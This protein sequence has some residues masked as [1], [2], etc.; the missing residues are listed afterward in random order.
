MNKDDWYAVAIVIMAAS[1]IAGLFIW[2]P[3]ETHYLTNEEIIAEINK[4]KGANLE[5][6][7]LRYDGYGGVGMVVCV[8][9]KKEKKW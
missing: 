6:D 7:L 2:N 8:P 1:V 5:A 9:E 3:L 4:C